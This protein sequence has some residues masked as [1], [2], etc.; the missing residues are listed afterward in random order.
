MPEKTNE[1][2]VLVEIALFIGKKN[3]PLEIV[4]SPELCQL[5]NQE[6]QN[7]I[8]DTPSPITSED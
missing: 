4:E 2:S 6:I 5:T 8:Q 1:W 3:S 7:G